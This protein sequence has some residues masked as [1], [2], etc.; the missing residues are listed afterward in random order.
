MSI[1]KRNLY[2]AINGHILGILNVGRKKFVEV[3]IS[4]KRRSLLM[5]NAARYT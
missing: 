2:E 5:I 4:Y 3:I 1:D